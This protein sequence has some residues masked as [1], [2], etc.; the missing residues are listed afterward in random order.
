MRHANSREL[1]SRRP[2]GSVLAFRALGGHPARSWRGFGILLCIASLAGQETD[3]DRKLR[4]AIR[5]VPIIACERIEIA[6]SPALVGI[7]AVAADPAG[8]LYVLHRPPAGDPLVVVDATGKR[9]RSWGAGLFKMPHG[10]RLDPDGNVWTVDAGSSVVYQ[11][12]RDGKKLREVR[13]GEIPDPTSAFC[14]ATDIAFAQN[15]DVFIADGYCNARVLVYDRLGRRIRQWGRKGGRP[16][17]FDVAHGI[18]MSPEGNVYVADRENG[19]VQWFDQQGAFLGLFEYGGQFYNVT[20]A[21][22]GDFWGSTHPKSAPLDVESNIVKID[23]ATGRL[24]GR[25][26]VR[27]HELAIAPDGTLLP[28]TRSSVLVRYRL[29]KTP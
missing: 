5:R 4:D 18:A 10:I 13:V 16:G 6:V 23:R 20:F 24:L 22:N 7:S 17:E 19:R 1:S 12:S 26:E 8:N 3:T 21:P 14:G 28:A 27:A 11:F 25:I 29:A 2:E 15:G 9:L